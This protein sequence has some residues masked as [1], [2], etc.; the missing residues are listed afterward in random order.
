MRGS[1]TMKNQAPPAVTEL[2]TYLHRQTERE[3]QTDEQNQS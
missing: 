3:K 1:Q 2:I